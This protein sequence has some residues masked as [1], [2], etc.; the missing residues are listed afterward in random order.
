MDY[1]GYLFAAF[2]VTWAVLFGYLLLLGRRL[3]RLEERIA[4]EEAN[5]A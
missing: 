5:D 2:A 4:D 1:T 3:Q